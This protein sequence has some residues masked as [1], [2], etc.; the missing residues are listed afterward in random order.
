MKKLISFC[1]A[2]LLVLALVPMQAQAVEGIAVD[3]TNF[4]D[5]NFRA[6]ILEQ[7]YGKD[8]ILPKRSL[9]GQRT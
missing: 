2:F 4:P 5:A 6:Y 7:Y 8:G 1:L 3:E 9:S